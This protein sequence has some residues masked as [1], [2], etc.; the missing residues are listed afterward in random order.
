MPINVR[1]MDGIDISTLNLQ[2]YDGAKNDPKYE[3]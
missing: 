2:K 3:V 1:T